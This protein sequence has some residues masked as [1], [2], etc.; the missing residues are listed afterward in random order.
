[1][2][3]TTTSPKQRTLNLSA[4]SVNSPS[5]S[6]LSSMEP[7]Q[8][9]SIP[10]TA[11]TCDSTETS[12][13]ATTCSG[14]DCLATT[15]VAMS[16]TRVSVQVNEN[17]NTAETNDQDDSRS[18]EADSTECLNNLVS[19][20]YDAWISDSFQYTSLY[21]HSAIMR[22]EGHAQ[23]L[24]EK[25]FGT[26]F[27]SKNSDAVV[28]IAQD[29]TPC[30]EPSA[31]IIGDNTPSTSLFSSPR[32]MEPHPCI[33]FAPIDQSCEEMQS[34]SIA[35][36]CPDINVDRLAAMC[37]TISRG[38]ASAEMD[39][40]VAI[41]DPNYLEDSFSIEPD[42]KENVVLA[43][44]NYL[45]RS[46]T[47]DTKDNTDKDNTVME[48]D[49]T[50]VLNV[51]VISEN[52]EDTGLHSR[53]KILHED[54]YDFLD[55]SFEIQSPSKS[56]LY[57]TSMANEEYPSRKANTMT[58][59]INKCLQ[60]P[61][62]IKENDKHDFLETS[63]EIEAPNMTIFATEEMPSRT[64]TAKIPKNHTSLPTPSN[65]MDE[66]DFL[67]LSFELAPRDIAVDSTMDSSASQ[68]PRESICEDR[69]I[70][71]LNENHQ[72]NHKAINDSNY[73]DKVCAIAATSDKIP[74]TANLAKMEELRQ[75]S[76]AWVEQDTFDTESQLYSTSPMDE[77]INCSKYIKETL[78]T[79]Q[80]NCRMDLDTH[81]NLDF[82]LFMRRLGVQV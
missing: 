66:Q 41:A 30:R 24:L 57:A 47:I 63:F 67:E 34:P 43:D 37:S 51:A 10:P 76:N 53:S 42:E 74:P 78:S 81:A 29:D 6:L 27:T 77:E 60:F 7:S 48:A 26:R 1:M 75:A 65:V 15:C 38:C 28:H 69:R 68:V 79:Q 52:R 17:V 25:S 36:T 32:S 4:D 3:M 39:E 23:D 58:P 33:S 35:T 50:H 19:Q 12:S 80:Y 55:T 62:S 18:M 64:T 5:A 20:V 11:Q 73:L 31:T 71:Y 46:F 59:K 45:E 70:S 49:P 22:G 2:D 8:F 54:D 9:L 61:Q 16:P 56:I 44:P 13:V 72:V 82:H 14:I 40:N 21:S